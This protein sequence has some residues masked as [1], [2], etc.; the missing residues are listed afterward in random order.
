MNYLLLEKLTIVIFTYNRHQY[1]KRSLAYWSN[2]NVKLVILDGSDKK[3]ENPKLKLK[4]IRYIHN[5]NG[6]YDRLLNSVK[7]ID[8]EFMILAADDEF[9]LP[10]ALCSCINFLMKD[11]TYSS[12][13][14][15]AIGFGFDNKKNIFGKQIYQKLKNLTLNQ[16]SS[17]ARITNH[18]SNY[19][20][21]HFYSVIKSNNWKKICPHVF[22]QKY[23]FFGS[24]ELQVEFLIILSGKSKIIS[25][26]MWMRS[27]GV[28]QLKFNLPQSKMQDWWSKKKFQD[29]KLKF[30]KSLKK[31][32]IELSFE[33]KQGYTE[34]DIS[35]FFEIYI[36]NNLFRKYEK[37]RQIKRSVLK[38]LKISN[39]KNNN[40]IN[41]VNIL[42]AEGVKINYGDLDEIIT[43]LEKTGG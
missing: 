1:L 10:S 14:G 22:K 16:K 31:A 42:E 8:T 15:R 6:L 11:N 28:Q 23:D 19:V 17:K 37:L 2:Y 35:N 25:E 21:A 13:G 27:H 12:C 41:E 5:T 36:N 39:N 43:T 29:E 33:K 20:P 24:I 3:F 26:L 40:L 34:D 7:H 4:N 32:S 18:F 30:L 38:W 9:Y